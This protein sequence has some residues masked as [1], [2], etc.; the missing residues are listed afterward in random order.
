MIS[1]RV[2]WRF[3]QLHSFLKTE[4]QNK[5]PVNAAERDLG[6]DPGAAPQTEY[7]VLRHSNGCF[8]CFPHRSWFM[9]IWGARP[10]TVCLFIAEEEAG[11]AETSSDHRVSPAAGFDCLEALCTEKRRSRKFSFGRWGNTDVSVRPSR[12]P[13]CTWSSIAARPSASGRSRALLTRLWLDLGHQKFERVS[14][15]SDQFSAAEMK[16]QRGVNTHWQGEI[17][18]CTVCSTLCTYTLYSIPTRLMPLTARMRSPV[19]SFW[20]WAAGE[21]GTTDFT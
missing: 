8:S 6:L 11:T 13:N 12:I 16:T 10:D 20:H 21:S 14:R 18:L 15:W 9:S 17:R 5:S 4:F 3:L 7:R 1:C 2:R 19:L